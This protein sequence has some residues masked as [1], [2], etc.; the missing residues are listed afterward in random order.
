[1]RNITII[2]IFAII[3]SGCIP[4]PVHTLK[5]YDLTI[6]NNFKSNKKINKVLK[7]KYPTALGAIGSSK[8]YYKKDDIT[9]YYL[10]SKWSDT[11]SRLIYKDILIS[12]Q[13]SKK[14]RSVIGYNS[15]A[16]ADIILET[17]I[18]NFYH[19]IDNNSSYAQITI[20]IKYIDANSQNIIKSK[21]FSYKIPVENKNAKSFVVAVKEVLKEFLAKL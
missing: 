1:M 11:L 10:Y 20:N 19:I 12:L 2:A 16:K 7:V 18:V 9:S 15:S 6:N 14:Y 8:I 13:N 3:L 21:V 4:K 17:Q 5:S